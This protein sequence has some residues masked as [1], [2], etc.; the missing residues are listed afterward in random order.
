[1]FLCLSFRCL[2]HTFWLSD[3]NSH[4]WQGNRGLCEA[5]SAGLVLCP[6]MFFIWIKFIELNLSIHSLISSFE[7][8]TFTPATSCLSVFFLVF[9]IF[10]ST[11]CFYRAIAFSI[12]NFSITSFILR[13]SS[14]SSL[15]FFSDSFL[16]LCNSSCNFSTSVLL[17]TFVFFLPPPGDVLCTLFILS[18]STLTFRS[19]GIL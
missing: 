3:P 9:L 2:S 19:C 12:S 18:D 5:C 6:P 15:Y 17:S 10:A 8:E 16:Y 13:C 11:S 14:F 7:I 4:K 1:M